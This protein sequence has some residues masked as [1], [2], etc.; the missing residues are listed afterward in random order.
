M[1]WQPN[2][3]TAQIARLTLS[4]GIVD[5]GAAAAL[6]AQAAAAAAAASAAAMVATTD[7]AMN[8]VLSNP[9]SASIGTL[10][11]RYV[12]VA[13]LGATVATLVAGKIPAAQLPSIAINEVYP[14]ASQAAMLALAA[15][16]GDV[17]VRTD[18]V[19]NQTFMLSASPASTLA[20][21]VEIGTS[22]PVSSV[23]GQVGA[24]TGTQIAADAA[25]LAAFESVVA[26][27]STAGTARPSTSL[28]V[29]WVGTVTPTNAADG[30]RWLNNTTGDE[31]VRISGAFQALNK[32]NN[33]TSYAARTSNGKDDLRTQ[34]AAA[35]R[36]FWQMLSQADTARCDVM[37]FGHSFIAG[38]GAVTRPA[39]FSA[40]L[41]AELRARWTVAPSTGGGEFVCGDGFPDF[42]VTG[43]SGSSN[44]GFLRNATILPSNG[45][46]ISYTFTG[47][48]ID[49]YGL[50]W[51]GGG[52][53]TWQ[54]DGGAATTVSTTNATQT[55]AVLMASI[56]GLSVGS[57]TLLVTKTSGGSVF[58][59]GFKPYNGDRTKGVHVWAGG[60]SGTTS[61]WMRDPTYNT[62]KQYVAAVQPSLVILCHSANDSTSG[63][64][65]ATTAA[66]FTATIADIRAQCTKPPSILI[67]V[68]YQKGGV[69]LSYPWANYV[70]ALKGISAADTGVMVWDMQARWNGPAPSGGMPGMID[71]DQI[72]PSVS[73]HRLWAKSL[74]TAVLP[75]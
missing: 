69:T 45:N 59:G 51:S 5:A 2:Y 52:S 35:L 72:H 6:A 26:H 67:V 63:V 64:T 19:P 42:S 17:A 75:Y 49:I 1:A 65:P 61:A 28:A 23:V 73:G 22:S 7:G 12:K 39:R 16:V 4:G 14:A 70:T 25:L 60:A 40:Q 32:A 71:T 13:Q 62:W 9:S 11:A 56:T 3:P 33:D 15:N 66:N 44:Y 34:D 10:D 29:Q 48:G 46:T 50:V 18:L 54:I 47:D 41:L 21:W 68:E 58:I 57:H 55:D 53:F 38:V 30:D 36:R 43:G 27:D 37:V 31:K 8:P 24:V 20:N 74:T